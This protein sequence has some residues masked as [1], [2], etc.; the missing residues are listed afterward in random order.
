M[1]QLKTTLLENWKNRGIQE[2]IATEL[3]KIEFDKVS[4]MSCPCCKSKLEFNDL[5]KYESLSE[6]VS[7]YGSSVKASYRCSDPTCQTRNFK[8]YWGNP[9]VVC[10]TEDGET[11]GTLGKEIKFIGDNSAP[12]GSF[13]RKL[14]VELK[15]EKSYIKI[16][17]NYQLMIEKQF[18]SDLDGNKLGFKTKFRI[19][20]D[21]CYWTPPIFTFIRLIF[22]GSKYALLKRGSLLDRLIFRSHFDY[23]QR[24]QYKNAHK[25]LKW[26][27]PKTSSDGK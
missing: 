11:Y 4:K 15:P 9:S 19:L 16:N 21:N 13:E 2:D 18:K 23:D 25:L 22:N 27:F 26:V 7:C 5:G 24:W 14:N 8:D 10:W 12:F 6:H 17:K 1:D 20:K 3:S